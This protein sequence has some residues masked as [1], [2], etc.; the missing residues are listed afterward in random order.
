MNKRLKKSKTDQIKSKQQTTKI[1]LD[2]SNKIAER[3]GSSLK[4]GKLTIKT[5][6]LI[7]QRN[8]LA[9]NSK[10]WTSGDKIRFAELTKTVKKQTRHNVRTYNKQQDS[11]AIYTKAQQ[12]WQA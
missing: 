1:L 10:T 4:A 5:F 11:T 9:K 7:K 6:N 2:A 8:D 3:Q 12:T